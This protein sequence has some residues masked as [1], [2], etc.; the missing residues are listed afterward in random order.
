M[1]VLL[2]GIFAY[3]VVPGETA[4]PASRLGRATVTTSRATVNQTRSR[5]GK[6]VREQASATCPSKASIISRIS[7]PATCEATLAPPDDPPSASA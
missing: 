5:P 6:P 4:R 3:I 7:D 2:I 1:V